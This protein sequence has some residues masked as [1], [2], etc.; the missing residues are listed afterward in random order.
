MTLKVLA[1]A[2]SPRRHGNSET[3]L[4]WLLASMAE[5]EGV[6]IEKIALTDITIN[7][8]KGCN[9][10]EKLNRCIQE[11]D[12]PRVLESIIEA[13]CIILASPIF[14]M[15]ICA[16]AKALVDRMQVFRSRKYVLKLPVAPP[17][18]KGK[19]LGAFLST[20]GQKWDIVFDAAIPPMKCFYHLSDVR[21]RDVYYLLVDGVDEKGAILDH[22][23]AEPDARRLGK[24]IISR[25]KVL[26][27]EVSG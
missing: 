25:L 18:R 10:C 26:A 21:D 3:L 13:D 4:D 27:G 22:P 2:T 15:G 17:E 14:C 19:R 9:A 5:E 8:C 12:L 11:D 20:A 24:E 7:P 6:E 23:T 1:F 16:Q